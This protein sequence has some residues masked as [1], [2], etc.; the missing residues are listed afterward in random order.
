MP[1]KHDPLKRMKSEQKA[2]R[3]KKGYPLSDGRTPESPPETHN[4]SEEGLK[5]RRAAERAAK[6]SRPWDK[7]K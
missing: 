7:W 6:K 1:K 3:L 4:L 5:L 2:E